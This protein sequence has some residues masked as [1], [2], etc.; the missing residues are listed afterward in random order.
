MTP[1]PRPRRRR[2][3]PSWALLGSAGLLLAGTLLPAPFVLEAPGPT[4]N[5]V[6]EHEGRQLLEVTGALTY[7]TE[8]V[9]DLTTVYVSGGPSSDV[10]V[11]GVL[12]AWLDPSTAVV[13]ADVLYPHRVS[14]EELDASNSVAMTS[15]QETSVAAALEHL[16]IEHST[17]LVVRGTVP[18]SPA[19]DR[20]EQGDVLRAVDGGPA[21]SVEQLR[22][23]LDAAGERGVRLRVERDGTERDVRVPTVLDEASGHRQ[24][25]VLLEPDHDFP[26]EVSFALEDVGGP[27]AG[28]MFALGIVD[29]LTPGSLAGD[30]HV[31]GTGTV[32]ADGLIGPIGGVRQKLDGAAAAGAELFLAPEGNC[33]EVRGH[34]PEGLTVVAVRDLDDAVAAASAAGRG[35]DL[36]A[37]PSCGTP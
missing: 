30:H 4:F 31:A 33:P 29:E 20:L 19:E 25:G 21:G 7:P 6:G 35:E 36:S 28:A 18:G 15:S 12:R 34:E 37:L 1:S 13:P 32:D 2:D 27:S 22:S 8:S 17:R 16:G 3:L 14:A 9:L 26:L 11:L 10:G 5:T 23:A 24:L